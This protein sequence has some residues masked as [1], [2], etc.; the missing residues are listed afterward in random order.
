MRACYSEGEWYVMVMQ[1]LGISLS[2][3]LMEYDLNLKAILILADQMVHRDAPI[4][5]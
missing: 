2:D 4:S 5:R 3:L 1:L